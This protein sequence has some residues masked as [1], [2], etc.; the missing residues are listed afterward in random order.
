[1]KGSAVEIDGFAFHRM[2]PR[3]E[4]DHS[5]D[6]VLRNVGIVV[7]RVTWRQLNQEPLAVIARVATGLRPPPGPSER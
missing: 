3:S 2:S 1:V 6:A 4:H 5:K 7:D